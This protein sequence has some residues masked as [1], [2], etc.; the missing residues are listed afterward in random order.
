MEFELGIVERR[1]KSNTAEAVKY[2][3]VYVFDNLPTQV[4][5]PTTV[6]TSSTPAPIKNG[7]SEPSATTN[8]LSAPA[9]FTKPPPPRTTRPSP[10]TTGMCRSRLKK[11]NKPADTIY[12]LSHNF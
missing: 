8:G 5:N 11:I 3:I 9:T 10:I 7:V 1:L 6:V 12:V 4:Q 2:V